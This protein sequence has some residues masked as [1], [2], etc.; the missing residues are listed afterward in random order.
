[1][2]FRTYRQGAW[3]LD[4]GL[5]VRTSGDPSAI[6]KT[7]RDEIHRLNPGVEIWSSMPMRD[8]MKAAFMAPVLASRILTAMGII[9]LGLASLGVYAVMTFVVNERTQE[10]G[11]RMALGAT[12][13]SLLSLVLRNGFAMAA[14]G[15]GCGLL[16]A[17]AASRLLAHLLYDVSPFDPL[18]FVGV[19]LL[20][21]AVALAAVL[22]PARRAMQADPA[23]TLRSE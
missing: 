18:T 12:P 11:L 10:F 19:P 16:I 14:W 17:L 9:A 23:I 6:A 21:G 4:L 15:V 3:N 8:H 7:I 5:V 22:V 13:R 20:L 2:F 1:M